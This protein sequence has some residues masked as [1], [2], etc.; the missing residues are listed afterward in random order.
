METQEL[1]AQAWDAVQ[2]SGVPESLH[3]TAFKEAVSHL[4]AGPGAS[5]AVPA[6][7]PIAKPAAAPDVSDGAVDDGEFF[8]RIAAEAEV[9]EDDLRAVL[10]F[11]GHEVT[12]MS[13]GT[14]L[15]ASKSE[16]VRAIV[17]LVAGARHAGLGENDVPG[18]A[19]RQACKDKSAFDGNFSKHVGRL[20]AYR[21]NGKKDLVAVG[22]S[23]VPEF[24]AVVHRL[25]GATDQS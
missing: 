18:E 25:T 19:V 21:F 2:R 7:P 12:V 1:L 5:R 4:R 9:D 13:T 20:S 11:D 8:R 6:E 15:G 24:E 22:A 16:R 23:W 10:H 17:P 3:E 14:K